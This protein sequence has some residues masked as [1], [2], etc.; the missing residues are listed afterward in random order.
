[1]LTVDLL[2][3]GDLDLYHLHVVFAVMLDD[4]SVPFELL[5]LFH[6]TCDHP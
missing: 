6:L 2:F 3:L 5:T 4:H 1:M